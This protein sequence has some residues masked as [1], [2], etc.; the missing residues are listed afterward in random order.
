M[1]IMEGLYL[2]QFAIF[3]A[4]FLI[5]Y[6][7]LE[8]LFGGKERKI[9]RDVTILLAFS[10]ALILSLSSIHMQ[11]LRDILQYI[12]GFLVVLFAGVLV[13]GA[14]LGYE[15]IKAGFKW[16]PLIALISIGLILG[17]VIILLYY[18]FKAP[19]IFYSS[20]TA[21]QAG[22][23]TAYTWGSRGVYF[24]P[25]MLLTFLFLILFAIVAFVIGR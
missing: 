25:K 2:P 21:Q 10:V 1:G 4:T 19:S 12:A 8:L 22:N 15:E 7:A 14:W 17:V 5:I 16:K 18:L 9:G 13:F 20:Q 6:T 24:D 23:T 3:M 11:F